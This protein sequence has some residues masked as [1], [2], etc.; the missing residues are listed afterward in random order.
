VEAPL[1]T[2][3]TLVRGASGVPDDM[4]EHINDCWEEQAKAEENHES[5]ASS[6]R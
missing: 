1:G 4:Y 3:A 2:P 5:N 6:H